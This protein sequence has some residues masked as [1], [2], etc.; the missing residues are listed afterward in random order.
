MHCL[1]PRPR[2]LITGR[3]WVRRS[4]A[5]AGTPGPDFPKRI[6]GVR[7]Q[8]IWRPKSCL[9]VISAQALRAVRCDKIGFRRRAWPGTWHR[10]RPGSGRR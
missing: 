5:W 6:K 2:R 7:Q 9:A 4:R 10:R 3:V 8:P 1:L